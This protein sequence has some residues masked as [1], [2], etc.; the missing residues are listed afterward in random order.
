ML[1]LIIS[2]IHRMRLYVLSTGGLEDEHPPPQHPAAIT[3]SRSAFDVR[4]RSCH[5][6]DTLHHR[7]S[8]DGKV[9]PGLMLPERLAVLGT[10]GV[11]RWFA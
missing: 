10:G 5:L 1:A 4:V 11:N 8:S 6:T 3:V 9:K 7:P 2:A